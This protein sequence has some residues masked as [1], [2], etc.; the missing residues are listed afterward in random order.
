MT[1]YQ[2]GQALMA[3]SVVTLMLLPDITGGENNRN[4][5][6]LIL[7]YGLFALG[8]DIVFGVSGLLSFGHASMFG[9]GGYT[10]SLLTIH[11][12][13]DFVVALLLAGIAGA[14][15]AF[16]FSVF[17]LR[18][19]GLFFA[20][21]TLALAQLVYIVSS[22]KLRGLSGGFDGIT[23]VP[24]PQML[25]I[26]FYD[27]ANYFYFVAV[28]FIFGLAVAALLRASA[29]GQAL[30]AVAANDV[31]AQQLGFNIHRMRQ[32]AFAISGAYAGISGAL[33]ASLLFY[34]SPQMMHWSTSGDILIMTMLGGKGTLLGPI[35]GVAFFE[36]LKEEIARYTAHW[37]GV[38]GLVFILCTIFLPK[39]IAGLF[40]WSRTARARKGEQ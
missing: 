27:N 40:Q 2:W 12:G 24:R 1:A 10:L 28:I 23:G 19:S 16:V 36:F 18:V 6:S 11:L 15:V 3:V 35:L 29:F 34:V 37:Y 17:A 9:I 20:L 33:L 13:V 8:Y 31:R 14:V 21:L 30:K 39:G 5:V 25:G 7:I 4:L 32:I 26:D 22:T 38:I